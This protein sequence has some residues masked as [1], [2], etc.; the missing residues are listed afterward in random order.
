MSGANGIRHVGVP[1]PF[2]CGTRVMLAG[3]PSGGEPSQRV[4]KVGL[5]NAPAA[6]VKTETTSP[7]IN[8]AHG[9]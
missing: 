9:H 8:G 5:E 6:N 2:D 1:S 7:S 4:S 3:I